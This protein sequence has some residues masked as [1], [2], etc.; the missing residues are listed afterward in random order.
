MKW[1]QRDEETARTWLCVGCGGQFKKGWSRTASGGGFLCG[2]CFPTLEPA[3]EHEFRVTFSAKG[4]ADGSGATYVHSVPCETQE[5]A[6]SVETMLVDLGQSTKWILPAT[7]VVE[8][9]PKPV[10][11][12]E[13][14]GWRPVDG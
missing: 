11:P 5:H 2:A 9:R 1:V 14:E 10:E 3:P 6:E 8:R 4:F 7:V 13:D 12:V